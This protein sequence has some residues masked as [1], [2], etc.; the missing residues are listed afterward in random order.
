M[1]SRLLSLGLLVHAAGLAACSS[2]EAN[3]ALRPDDCEGHPGWAIYDDHVVGAGYCVPR[4]ADALP[5][6]LP[7][8]AC[9]DALP[10]AA[11]CQEIAPSW[12]PHPQGAMTSNL[13]VDTLHRPMLVELIQNRADRTQMRVIYELN[14]PAVS[15]MLAKRGLEQGWG[16]SGSFQGVG[17]R[18]G[19]SLLELHDWGS[20]GEPRAIVGGDAYELRP[21]VLHRSQLSQGANYAVAGEV[22]THDL[23]GFNASGWD[24]PSAKAPEVTGQVEMVGFDD[25]MFLRI[26]S[27][28]EHYIQVYSRAEGV[29]TFIGGPDNR[30]TI[31]AFGLDGNHIVWARHSNL[32]LG[33][34]D[35]WANATK[36]FWVAP[37]AT[38]PAELK[39]TR[40]TE[41]G[42]SGSMSNRSAVGCGYAAF[43]GNENHR[44][45]VVRLFDGHFWDIDVSAASDW[46]FAFA[47]A[48]TCDEII[49]ASTNQGM[50]N[51]SRIRLE[52][53]GPPSPPI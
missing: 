28:P 2:N 4:S 21:A 37:Y 40:L 35:I 39:P 9:P 45:L 50:F 34:D 43:S 5:E 30:E 19:K 29:R 12:D 11:G 49:F 15:A 17:L 8:R 46:R 7:W 36:E 18:Q 23:Q 31:G 33:A 47:L 41:V 22:W 24:G 13:A 51:V 42:Y 38:A 16:F 3:P 44:A 20:T 14:G 27:Y 26:D 6:P 32:D 25:H 48:A 53:L 1:S 52:A 10:F